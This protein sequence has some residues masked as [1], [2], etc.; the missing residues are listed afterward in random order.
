MALQRGSEPEEIVGSAL[1][2]A[3][4]APSFTTG[5]VLPVDGGSSES[6]GVPMVPE[7]APNGFG[8]RRQ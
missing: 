6:N 3:S 7:R 5:A 8:T 1:Y 4:D 2:L